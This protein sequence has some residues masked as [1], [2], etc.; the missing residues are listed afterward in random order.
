[1]ISKPVIALAFVSDEVQLAYDYCAARL[2]DG[3]EKS[4]KQYFELTDQIAHNP[5]MFPV[6]F[7]DYHRAMI[8]KSD[9]AIY[10]F[11]EPDRAPS[12]PALRR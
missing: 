6:K 7:D 11:Q 2:K 4:L 8:P 1:M 12:R 9:L 5:P 3:G 10:Y